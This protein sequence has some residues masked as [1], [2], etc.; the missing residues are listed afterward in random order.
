MT[1][2]AD[3]GFADPKLF[4]LLQDWGAD[5]VIRMRGNTQ[6]ESEG[7]ET[8]RAEDGVSPRG[9]ARLLKGARITK[10]RAPV[11]A[12]V[13]VTSGQHPVVPR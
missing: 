8:C 3:R 7:A 6:V 9:K 5:Y 4:A 13:C 10:A 2:L 11:P 1:V 12:V